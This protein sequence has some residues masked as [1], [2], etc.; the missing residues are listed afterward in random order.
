[1]IKRKRL[2]AGLSALT[3][4]CFLFFAHLCFPPRAAAS[5]AALA[6]SWNDTIRR[7]ET[8]IINSATYYG[9][10]PDLVA[11]IIQ[12]ESN[13][14][15]D[16]VSYVGA[17]GLMGVMPQGPGFEFRPAA[18]AL[19][20]PALNISWGCA[21]LDDILQQ[22]GGDLSAALAAYNG[23]W[24]YATYRV[25]RDYADNV[26]HEYG[27]A[28]AS[29]SGVDPS[30]AERWTVAVRINRGHIPAESLIVGQP[31][32]LGADPIGEHVVYNQ[33]GNDGRAYFVKGFAMPLTYVRPA[34]APAIIVPVQ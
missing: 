17:V 3:L 19:T 30:I 22:S 28:V 27:R 34:D 1:M 5:T 21:I 6:P 33:W 9:L 11:A 4:A 12:V 25:P 23:G 13:G 24:F 10:D 15:P 32:A 20:A 18:N 8:E 16:S 2:T 31:P 26:L 14:I 7:W 29:R